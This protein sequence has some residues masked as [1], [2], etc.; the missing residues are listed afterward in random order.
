MHRP[1]KAKT[2]FRWASP[3]HFSEEARQ[4]SIS[5]PVSQEGKKILGWGKVYALDDFCDPS[6][7]VG[8]RPR[9]L[10]RHWGLYP[11]FASVGVDRIVISAFRRTTH[12]SLTMRLRRI[13]PPDLPF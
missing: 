1:D 10:S 4:P 3:N 8:N 5:L 11:H 9:Q 12:R 6:G 2:V 13:A 7:F